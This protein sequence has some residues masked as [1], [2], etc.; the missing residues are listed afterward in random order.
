MDEKE[1]RKLKKK[2]NKGKYPLS[3]K[4]KE[5]YSNLM[6]KIDRIKDLEKGFFEKIEKDRQDKERKAKEKNDRPKYASQVGELIFRLSGQKFLDDRF[7]KE[8]KWSLEHYHDF[9]KTLKELLSKAPDGIR[10]E[11]EIKKMEKAQEKDSA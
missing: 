8:L 11:K 10:E 4:E 1:Y 3:E 9:E 6:D 5:Q 2:M 7:V